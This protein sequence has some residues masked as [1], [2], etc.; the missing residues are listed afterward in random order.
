M[1]KLMLIATLAL[2][3]A[4]AGLFSSPRA[5]AGGNCVTYCSTPNACGYVCCFQQCCDGRCID[6]DC[7]PPP[8]CGGDN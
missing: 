6:L 3:G 1:R 8:P 2:T 7:A 4:A 5:E